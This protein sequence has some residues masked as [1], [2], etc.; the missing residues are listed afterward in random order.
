M[1]GLGRIP[2]YSIFLFGIVIAPLNVFLVGWYQNADELEL[3]NI[4]IPSYTSHS[5]IIISNNM[6]FNTQG[7]SGNGSESHPF[8]IED[9][10]ITN[11]SIC[12]AISDTDVYFKIRNCFIS[13]AEE[14]SNDGIVFSNVKNGTVKDCI[15]KLHNNGINIVDS[16]SC[17]LMNNSVIDNKRD[18][19]SLS[20][21][22]LCNLSENFALGNRFY[23]YAVSQSS[24]C[25]LTNNT[26]TNNAQYGFSGFSI[27]KSSSCILTKNIATD[28]AF[29]GFEISYSISCVFTENKLVANGLNLDGDSVLHWL[30]NISD[31]LVNDQTLGYFMSINNT[32]IDGT[33]YGQIILANCTNVIVRNGIII[34]ASVGIRLGFCTNCALTNNI[35]N[36]NSRYGYWIYYSSFCTLTNNTSTNNWI[37]FYLWQC[38]SCTLVN[39]TSI[40]IS[41]GFYPY[42]TS[43][44]YFKQ[45]SVRYSTDGF[46]LH[47]SSNCTLVENVFS[48]NEH[49]GLHIYSSSDCIMTRNI[50]YDN[51]YGI[52]VDTGCTDNIFYLNRIRN[53]LAYDGY[54]NGLS[55]RW[56]NGTQGNYWGSYDGN[57]IYLIPGSA[58]SIDHYPYLFATSSTSMKPTSTNT[59]SRSTVVSTSANSINSS[60]TPNQIP[61]IP[62]EIVVVTFAVLMIL[63]L[64]VI[65]IK[66]R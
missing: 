65:A 6:D 14:S 47:D 19:I 48:E 23:G 5:P 29:Y 40:D 3:Q 9:L 41:L 27:W 50:A 15:V 38:N 11:S 34:D 1:K 62:I 28:N 10:I 44:C 7:W 56:D 61:G 42:K 51:Q 16:S 49:Y 31:N 39:N 20:H 54:D 58:G 13:A 60:T 63:C 33:Q 22:T 17:N 2:I 26:A 66:R 53:N 25:L 59:N 55:N 30:H 64:V 45:N 4:L 18:G 32:Q 12:I 46:F 37:G 35:A 52:H 43:Y 21:S 36:S 24:S 8:V 57:G